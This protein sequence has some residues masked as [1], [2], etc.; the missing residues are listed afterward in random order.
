MSTF[1]QDTTTFDGLIFL[2]KFS[3]VVW[4]WHNSVETIGTIWVTNKY[5]RQ[6]R[7]VKPFS[8]KLIAG[9]YRLKP[10]LTFPPIKKIQNYLLE[11]KLYKYTPIK[12]FTKKG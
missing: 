7:H 12:L 9:G 8:I 3:A 11:K 4:R 10:K 6:I 2:A 1:L 5:W